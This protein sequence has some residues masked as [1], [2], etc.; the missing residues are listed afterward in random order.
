VAE[1][2]IGG[3]GVKANDQKTYRACQEPKTEAECAAAWQA[4]ADDVYA[5]RVKHKIP[6]VLVVAKLLVVY[7]DGEEGVGYTRLI[8]GSQLEAEP[9][10]SWALGTA[11]AERRELITKLAADAVKQGTPQQKELF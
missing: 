4:F 9:M 7:S 3:G 8:C 11:A 1:K 2:A 5:A 6:D 10:A